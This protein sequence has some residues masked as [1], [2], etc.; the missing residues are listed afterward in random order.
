MLLE[1]KVGSYKIYDESVRSLITEDGWVT[2]EVC[3][4]IGV[5]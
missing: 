1:A 5:F 2:D 4:F 3:V